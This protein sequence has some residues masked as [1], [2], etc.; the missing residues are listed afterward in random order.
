MKHVLLFLL[1]ILVLPGC[2]SQNFKEGDIIFQTSQS[3]QAPLI[4]K[5]TGSDITHCG[6]IIEK[7]NQFYVLETLGTI[8]LTPVEKFI[9]RGLFHRYK[10][11]HLKTP[12]NIKIK[13]KKY[14]GIP[15]DLAFKFNNGKYYCSELIYDIYK[16]QLGIELCKPKKLKSYNLTGLKKIAAKRGMNMNQL[17]VAPS[18]LYDSEYLTK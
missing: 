10:V 6:I 14:L 17:V 1:M 15:Y 13:Y 7:N 3:K 5:A 16:T 2:S 8:K 18:D 9:K 11:K 4:A 12:K